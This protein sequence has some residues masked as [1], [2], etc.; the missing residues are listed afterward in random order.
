MRFKYLITFVVVSLFSSCNKWLDVDLINQ[1]DENKLFQKEQGFKDALA[2]VYN[3]MSSSS[4][5]GRTLSYEMLDVM[6]QYYSYSSM[7]Q[8]YHYIR[9]FDYKNVS[10]KQKI[11]SIWN[12]M[13]SNIAA[14]N[15]IIRWEE[16]NG[17][18]M[19]D[20]IRKQIKG[21]AL[22]LR[23]Y[24]HFDLYRMFS[25]DMKYNP[26]AQSIPYNKEFG[27]SLPPRYTS[28]QIVQLIINDLQASMSYLEQVD[29]I[30][31]Q[32]PYKIVGTDKDVRGQADKFVARMNLYAVKA[33]LARVYIT[34]GDKIN[35]AK[36]AK[37]VIDSEK[38]RLLVFEESV[39][40]EEIK[41]DI[42]FSD[43]HIFSLRNKGIP[44]WSKSLF[45]GT[46]SESGENSSIKLTLAEGST[47]YDSNP[48]DVRYQFWL[49]LFKLKKM[50]ENT[51]EKGFFPKIPMIKL[52]EMYLIL[53]ES[54][55]DTD[56]SKSLSLLNVYRKSRIRNA[57][58][59]FFIDRDIILKEYKKDFL[60]EGQYWFTLKR[61]NRNISNNS[62]N[63]D[64][65][66]S[67]DIYVF[68]LPDKE[69]ESGFRN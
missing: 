2:G 60:G 12:D 21:E 4:L 40:V 39:D 68:P 59:W 67:K 38:F 37:E 45:Y 25:E 35:A 41:R 28:G 23:A 11:A 58:D 3:K 6:A 54:Y 14:I 36:M 66:A 63:S 47:L 29:P 43:E 48:D 9:D 34:Q 27:V 18:V 46:Q 62:G 16:K 57:P 7:D 20:D 10:V 53:M 55:Y 56:R 64:I 69:I 51:G 8:S 32:I 33:M 61:L 49:D 19:S 5:Y 17:Q 1:V 22:A 65:P 50:S 15:N 13:Y 26:T 24:L 42:R 44:D 52:S 30:R 31:N